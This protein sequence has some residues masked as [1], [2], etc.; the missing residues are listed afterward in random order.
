MIKK[1]ET[2]EELILF[3]EFVNEIWREEG[4]EEEY[5]D[6]ST[7]CFNENKKIIGTFELKK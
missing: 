1:V 2:Q 6:G 7:E 5:A 3:N 4:D